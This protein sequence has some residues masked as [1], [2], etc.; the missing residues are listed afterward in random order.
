MTTPQTDP[1][2]R[3]V[4]LREVLPALLGVVVL[5]VGLAAA[6]RYSK[7]IGLLIVAAVFAVMILSVFRLPKEQKLK[8]AE[9]MEDQDRK[10]LGQ[11][12][13]V[14]RLAVWLM[15]LVAASQWLYGRL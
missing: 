15:L 1:L 12:L 4:P 14:I 3:H 5:F 13:K 2:R 7:V 9:A 11:F 6:H 10:P 8:V